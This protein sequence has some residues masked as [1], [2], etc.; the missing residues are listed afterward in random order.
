MGSEMCIRDRDNT[1]SKIFA[2]AYYISF[3]VIGNFIL[4]NVFLGIIVDNL[5]SDFE[6]SHDEHFSDKDEKK[7]TRSLINHV[8]DAKMALISILSCPV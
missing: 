8:V 5:A 1:L 6:E 7:K 4:M 3:I 2:V